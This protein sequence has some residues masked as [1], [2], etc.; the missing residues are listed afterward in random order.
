MKIDKP[1]DISIISRKKLSG[2]IFDDIKDIKSP[3]ILEFGV[4]AGAGENSVANQVGLIGLATFDTGAVVAV[5]AGSVA[6]FLD[7]GIDY[8]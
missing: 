6:D 4:R 8:L 1:K 2:F 3:Q 7:G 5:E